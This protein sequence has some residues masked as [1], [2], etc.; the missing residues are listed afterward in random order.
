MGEF[1]VCKVGVALY[2]C[3]NKNDRFVDF[4]SLIN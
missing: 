3:S 1:C 2:F 4:F